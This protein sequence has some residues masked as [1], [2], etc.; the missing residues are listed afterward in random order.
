MWG[1]KKNTL[2]SYEILR[3]VK[4]FP[5]HVR[6]KQTGAEFFLGSNA[7]WGA[8]PAS[9][10]D[11]KMPKKD[12]RSISPRKCAGDMFVCPFKVSTIN[13]GQFGSKDFL[14]SSRTAWSTVASLSK[15]VLFES[16]S[17]PV[18]HMFVHLPPWSSCDRWPTPPKLPMVAVGLGPSLK[19]NS[20]ITVDWLDNIGV[21]GEIYVGDSRQN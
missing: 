8:K 10:T 9:N 16:N 13:T 19:I 6:F 1:T 12:Q 14:Y 7:L 11:W 21:R 4:G 18:C 5:F 2:L 3:V 15:P 20:W 17:F